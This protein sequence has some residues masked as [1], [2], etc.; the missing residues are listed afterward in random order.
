MKRIND[1]LSQYT[2]DNCPSCYAQFRRGKL[3]LDGYFDI[4]HIKKIMEI[5]DSSVTLWMKEM[6]RNNYDQR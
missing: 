5:I 6:E 3:Q 1:I 2:E 4:K